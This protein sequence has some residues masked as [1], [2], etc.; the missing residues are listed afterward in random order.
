MESPG[1]YPEAVKAAGM[2]GS[3]MAREPQELVCR[4]APC[5]GR[6]AGRVP[7]SNGADP[8]VTQGQLAKAAFCDRST[9][10]HIETGWS[11]G[12]RAVLDG[13]R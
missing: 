7:P 3:A 9:V 1:D 6:A 12:G 10:A 8:G 11:P 2:V 4:D 13:C 5:P